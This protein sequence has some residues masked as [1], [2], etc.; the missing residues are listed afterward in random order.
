MKWKSTYNWYKNVKNCKT[1][2]ISLFFQVYVYKK[3]KL[4]NQSRGYWNGAN[5]P[6]LSWRT[7]ISFSWQNSYQQKIK[8]DRQCRWFTFEYQN[9]I[10][11]SLGFYTTFLILK[12]LHYSKNVLYFDHYCSKLVQEVFLLCFW[13]MGGAK[14][15][16]LLLQNSS[17]WIRFNW[18]HCGL[19]HVYLVQENIPQKPLKLVDIVP[20]SFSRIRTRFMSLKFVVSFN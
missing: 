8:S 6:Q 9:K 4:K 5:R 1:R 14:I 7:F 11:V 2:Y 15:K 19:K 3:S 18:P 12:I 10:Q 20:G 17:F 16:R 13:S